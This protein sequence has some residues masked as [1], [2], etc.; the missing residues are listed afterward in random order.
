[1]TTRK[2]VKASEP[3]IVAVV[4]SPAD[5]NAAIALKQ[6]PDLFELRLDSLFPITNRLEKGI[7]RLRAPLIITARDPREGGTGGLLFEKR[8]ELLLRFLPRATYI[9][10]ELRSARKFKSLLARAQK[11]NIRRVLSYH[12]FQSTPTSRSLCAKARI[13]R[14][15]GADVFKVATRTDIPAALARLIDFIIHKNID[16]PVSA[17]GM[18][19][20]GALSRLL[21][22]R[23]GSVL[24]YASLERPN[25]EGQ[26]SIALLRSALGR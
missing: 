20:L 15:L 17:M 22:A 5:L 24:N 13:A 6:L 12:D 3:Q 21:L 11:N 14:S 16:L 18:G 26:T 8:C 7:S 4:A 25:V 23:S 10:V 1:M 19:R 9:D 2:R